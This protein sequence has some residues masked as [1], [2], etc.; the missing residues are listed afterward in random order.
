M[1]IFLRY[2]RRTQSQ[3]FA[4][5]TDFNLENDSGR[6]V[7]ILGDDSVRH[8]VKVHMNTC[9]IRDGYRSRDVRIDKCE[10]LSMVIRKEKLLTV[11]FLTIVQHDAT[12]SVYYISVGSSTC[13][14][15]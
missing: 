5:S 13:F 11:K 2:V 12:Y 6:T 15:C 10:A 9:S 8:C 14:G 3:S 7:N 1:L 4:L